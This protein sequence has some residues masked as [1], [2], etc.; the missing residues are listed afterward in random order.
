MGFIEA[1]LHN[2]KIIRYHPEKMLGEGAEKEFFL[3]EDEN[4]V[5]GFYK[6]Q[7]G[8]EDKER[9]RRLMSVIEKYNPTLDLGNGEVWEKHFCWPKAFVVKPRIGIL[10]PKFPLQYYFKDGKGEKKGK[11]FSS[12]RLFKKLQKKER[13]TLLSRLKICRHLTQA[14]G[15]MHAAGLAHSDLSSNN[16]LMDASRGTSLVIDID[17]LVVPGIFQ[18]KVL[19][20]RGYMAPEVVKTSQL[21]LMHPE[22]KM[23]SIK[24]DL[25]ALAVIIYETLLLRHPLEGKKSYSSNFETDELLMFGEKALFIEN[26]LDTSNCPDNMDVSFQSLGPH[27]V[28]LFQRVFI[29]GLHEPDLRPTAYE[30]EDVLTRTLDI[31]YPCKGSNCWQKWF[32]YK[33]G[34]EPKCPFCGRKISEPIPIMHLFQKFSVGQYLP[35]KHYLTICD[36]KKL[37]AWHS[38]SDVFCPNEISKNIK[39]EGSFS[40]D[41]QKWTFRNESSEKMVCSVSEQIRPG[42]SVEISNGKVI[43]LST[44]PK[45]RLAIFEVTA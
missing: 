41:D 9:I 28:S 21:D 4:L 27:L 32:V 5:I 22:K 42:D 30:W 35:E 18:P 23:P 26:P 13:G 15:R 45:G 14:I 33:K 34:S 3:T 25:H 12:K 17:S 7:N 43:L 1:Q 24:T 40:L 16:V 39:W 19:G 8:L 29:D 6:D 2:G 44:A 10:S 38:R 20:T 36:K 11:W 31:L 37:Y